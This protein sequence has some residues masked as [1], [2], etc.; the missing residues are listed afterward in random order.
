MGMQKPCDAHGNR[1]AFVVGFVVVAANIAL[2][3]PGDFLLSGLAG[4]VSSFLTVAGAISSHASF[5]CFHTAISAIPTTLNI[6][7]VSC[8]KRENAR[9]RTNTS[10]PED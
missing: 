10:M 6:A 9:S 1:I 8:G 5:A 2:L 7:C 3:S 4:A